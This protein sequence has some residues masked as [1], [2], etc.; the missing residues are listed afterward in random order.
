MTGAVSQASLGDCFALHN[1]GKSRETGS[2]HKD[3]NHECT[4]P[5]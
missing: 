4:A 3:A 2:I 5:R 1:C